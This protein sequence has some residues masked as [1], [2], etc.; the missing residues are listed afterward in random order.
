MLALKY[1]TVRDWVLGFQV[2]L[3]NREMIRTGARTLKSNVG[4]DR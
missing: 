1:G 4:Y 2:V 3:A